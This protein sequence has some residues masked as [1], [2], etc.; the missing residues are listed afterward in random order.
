[1]SVCVSE[2]RA[3]ER[4]GEHSIAE[5]CKGSHPHG[6]VVML[7]DGHFEVEPCELAQMSVSVTVL[8]SEHGPNLKYPG[9]SSCKG[10]A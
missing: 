3:Q 6:F 4:G 5:Q 8:C 1:M 9:V 7:N 2:S 10:E